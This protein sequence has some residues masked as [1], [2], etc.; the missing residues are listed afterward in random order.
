MQKHMK[1]AKI[2]F[3]KPISQVKMQVKYHLYANFTARLLHFA[4]FTRFLWVIIHAKP[5][6]PITLCATFSHGFLL[7]PSNSSIEAHFRHL[8]SLTS[9]STINFHP[10][11]M[12]T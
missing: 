1:N 9:A 11:N 6:N 5:S 10:S 12:R 7:N 4:V 3:R 8:I 2:L